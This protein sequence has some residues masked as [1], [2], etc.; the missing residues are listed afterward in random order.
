MQRHFKTFFKKI[1]PIYEFRDRTEPK[2]LR[3]TYFS[4]VVRWCG[5]T[6]TQQRNTQQ[7]NTQQHTIINTQ[8]ILQHNNNK[9]TQLIMHKSSSPNVNSSAS[10]TFYV[11]IIYVY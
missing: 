1:W 10:L 7:R 5:P 6:T 4:L 8:H 11:C 2:R 9:T 3:E